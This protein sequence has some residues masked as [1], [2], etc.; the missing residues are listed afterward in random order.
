MTAQLADGQNLGPEQIRDAC[1][2]L[3]GELGPFE[4]RVDFLR[5]LSKKGVSGSELAGFARELLGRARPFPGGGEGALDVC[6]TGG[7]QA[8]LFNV[9][10]ATLF[11]VAGAGVRV[12]KHGNRR[13]TSQSGGADVLEALGVAIALTPDQSRDLLEAAGFCFLFAPAY[14]PAIKAAT[15]ARK[16]LADE[17][18]PT[19]FNL[20]GP[21]LN[22]AQPDYQLT[23][24]FS[25]RF[26]KIYA[27]ALSSLGRKSAWVVHGEGTHGEPL[28]EV[29]PCGIT[30]GHSIA[31]AGI[32]PIRWHAQDLGF[33]HDGLAELRGGDPATNARIIEGI[34]EGTLRGAAR[35]VVI[36]N[37]AAALVVAGAAGNLA[38]GVSR[39]I[40]S[41]DAGAALS[42]LQ[43]ARA[44]TVAAQP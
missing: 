13:I 43:A 7:D 24:I 14:H 42:R 9:S 31:P 23:G 30:H 39:A 6:G 8:N 18:I 20:L 21:L 15:P 28:D 4:A 41:V 22:P 16:R 40:E 1:L 37:S 25:P 19:I 5:A 34:L 29:S 26:L 10:T 17:G 44:F 33:Q 35:D 3:L 27:E 38:E 11:V 32:R 2:G 12:I 36:L